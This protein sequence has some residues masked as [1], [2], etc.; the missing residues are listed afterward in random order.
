[1]AAA[2]SLIAGGA[3]AQGMT[4]TTTTTTTISPADETEMHNYVVQEH[5]A[6]IVAPNGFVVTNGAVLPQSVDI[7]SFPSDHHW[8]YE[9]TTIGDSTVLIDP[10]TRRIVHVLH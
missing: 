3:L 10:A 6:P 4:E 1:M 9:Y 8:N 5:R 7:Y 2:L